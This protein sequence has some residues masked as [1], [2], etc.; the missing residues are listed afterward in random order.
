MSLPSEPERPRD[1]IVVGAG[2]VGLCLA[3]GLA[4]QG[5]DVLVVEKNA[6]TAEHSRAPA[7]WPRTQEV[8]ADLGV[9]HA[10]LD[11]GIVM[12]R[13]SLW[14][15]DRE[16][17]V[18]TLPLDELADQTAY[19]HLLIVPQSRTE[20]LLLRALEMEPTVEVRFSCEAIDLSQDDSEVQLS[21]RDPAGQRS[22]RATFVAGCDGAHSLV[23]KRIGASMLGRTYRTR[24]ALADVEIAKGDSLPSPR[25]TTRPR[26]AIGIRIR[27]GLWRL[28]LPFQETEGL[29][30]DERLAAAVR[31]LFALDVGQPLWQSE[32]RLH[33]RVSSRFAHRRVVLA[34]D[35]AHLNS[36][37]GGQGMNAGIQDAGVLV[38]IL[39]S[40]L[41]RGEPDPFG[42]YAADRRRSITRGVN[43]FTD[44]MTRLLLARHGRVIK[45]MLRLVSQAMRLPG[46]RRRAMRRIAMLDS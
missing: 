46:F 27:A 9:I 31:S 4:R 11:E 21:V 8:L 28:I 35:A 25:I 6:A 34:G 42:A 2:P 14:D 3:L 40:A 43:R 18:L 38:D 17:A 45:P 16:R 39:A 7:I 20:R 19:P 23:R 22:L 41:D 33:N 5:R 1:L 12:S 13:L 24:A 44:L 26:L 30:M 36:P 29:P 10:F 32:F 37:V 15:V